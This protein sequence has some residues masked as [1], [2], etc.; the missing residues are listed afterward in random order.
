DVLVVPGAITSKTSAGSNRLLYQGAT[1][2]VDDDSFA[3]ILFS[4]FG[5]LKME[6]NPSHP[7]SA[8]SLKKAAYQNDPL[9]EA[10]M[11]QP[12]RKDQLLGSVRIP[13]GEDGRIWIAVRLAELEAEGLVAR[14]P[15]GRYGPAKV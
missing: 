6:E 7:P 1:P 2:I 13:K 15:D 3:D 5:C 4:L 14:Y 11:A 8:L 9:Y 12:M 10:L